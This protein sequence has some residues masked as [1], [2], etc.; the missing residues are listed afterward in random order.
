MLRVDRARLTPIG[1]PLAI[2]VV[3]IFPDELVCV[4]KSVFAEFEMAACISRACRGAATKSHRQEAP[5]KGCQATMCDQT[6]RRFGVGI[7]IRPL[8][9]HHSFFLAGQP[10]AELPN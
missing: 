7:Q 1:H 3:M 10:I 9:I 6:A 8:V 5:G 2:R 4:R